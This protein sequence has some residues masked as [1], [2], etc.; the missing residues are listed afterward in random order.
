[1]VELVGGTH[2]ALRPRVNDSYVPLDISFR[3]R[4]CRKV[5]QIVHSDCCSTAELI[6]MRVQLAADS[7][8]AHIEQAS[9]SA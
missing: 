7:W 1:M 6:D 5:S 9:D 4:V 8:Q 2:I 3:H